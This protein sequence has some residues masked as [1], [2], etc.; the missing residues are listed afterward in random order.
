MS[1]LHRQ[2]KQTVR[3]WWGPA[4]TYLLPIALN[5]SQVQSTTAMYILLGVCALWTWLLILT[6]D[7]FSKVSGWKRLLRAVLALFLVIP[8]LWLSAILLTPATAPISY[9]WLSTNTW[10]MDGDRVNAVRLQVLVRDDPPS[11]EARRGA[12]TLSSL[13]NLSMAVSTPVA[14]TPDGGWYSCR[15]G[16]LNVSEWNN[17]NAISKPLSI[18]PLKNEATVL[19]VSAS[20]RNAN[21]LGVVV[22]QHK[23]D[24]LDWEAFLGGWAN[25]TRGAQP[26][27][28]WEIR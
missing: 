2:W 28:I 24:H 8:P 20:S 11:P 18:L 13:H 1:D 17:H 22:I 3:K 27:S 26:V 7:W 6:L 4:V 12:M 23:G 16:E 19:E 10:I 25:T 21:W 14:V 15:V 9:P 5:F